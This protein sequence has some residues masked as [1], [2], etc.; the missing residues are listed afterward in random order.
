M[1]LS[2]HNTD[3]EL[4]IKKS[5]VLN[6]GWS[7][8]ARSDAF[9]RLAKSGF[10]TVRDEYWKYTNPKTLTNKIVEKASL[11]TEHDSDIFK[12]VSPLKIVFVDGKFS[13]EKSDELI[14]SGLSIERLDT[15]KKLDLHWAKELYGRYEKLGQLS[16]CRPL[17]AYNTAYSNEG[18]IIH[19]T[20][21]VERPINIIYEHEDE[22]SDVILHHVIKIDSNA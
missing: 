19:V 5:A 7:A 9:Q 4:E 13:T 17:A 12:S 15:I 6:S 2:K 18:L 20:D 11:V 16:V 1:D 22:Y 3:A 10:P 21:R 8:K 14:L